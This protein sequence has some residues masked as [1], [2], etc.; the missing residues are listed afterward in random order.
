M[1]RRLKKLRQGLKRPMQTLFAGALAM[2]LDR[3]RRTVR[4]LDGF[5]PRRILLS[6]TDRIGDLLCCSPL[7]LALHRRWPAASLVLVP[8]RKNRSVLEGLPFV[9]AGPVFERHPLS[10]AELAWRLGREVFDLY[11]SLR[12]ESMA[13]VWVGAWSGAPI[14]LATH[15]TYAAPSCNLI[16]GVD[17]YHQTTRYCRAAELLGEKPAAI[18]PVFEVPADAERRAAGIASSLLPADGRQV[19]GFQIPHRGSRRHAVRAWPER[20][21]AELVGAL[22]ADGCRVVLCGTRGER[23]EAE[24]LRARFPG[25]VVPPSVP[26][27]VFAGL[28]RRFDLFVSQFTGTLHLADAVGVP[29]I[30]FGLEDQVHGW[31]AV[32][33]EHRNIGAARVSEIPVD[34]L[35]EATRASLAAVTARSPRQSRA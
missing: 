30:G 35:L 34:V 15:R 21:V 7:L 33:A 1:A 6:R 17:D 19:V 22:S 29:V 20:K 5:E 2:P 25:V 27:A 24:A 9:A 26:L 31:A 14:R 28:Q 11:V 8:G 16:L 18:R 3:R 12:A 13:G 4:D 32:G 23:A 10:W